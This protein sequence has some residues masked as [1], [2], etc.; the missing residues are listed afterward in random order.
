[1]EPQY[2]DIDTIWP[3]SSR[4]A[5]RRVDCTFLVARFVHIDAPIFVLKELEQCGQGA[6]NLVVLLDAPIFVLKELEQ[7]GQ[8]ATNLVV[9]LKSQC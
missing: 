7:C 9:L 5:S 2:V 3:S 6:T 4:R 8:G 1:M